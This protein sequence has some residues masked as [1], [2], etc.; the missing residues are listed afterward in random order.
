MVLSKI[1]WAS[2]P[3]ALCAIATTFSHQRT[4][5]SQEVAHE[6]NEECMVSSTAAYTVHVYI[7][8]LLAERTEMLKAYKIGDVYIADA[9][10]RVSCV[11]SKSQ[12]AKSTILLRGNSFFSGCI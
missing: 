5:I 11:V 10:S 3:L 1:K 8:L 2:K 12:N 6:V 4:Q 9:V 7:R